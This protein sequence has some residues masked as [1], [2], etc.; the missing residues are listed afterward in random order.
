[1]KRKRYKG[2]ITVFFSLIFTII[3]A[4]ICTV[5]ESARF[6]AA[7]TRAKSLSYMAMESEFAGYGRQ[8]FD[9]YGLLLVYEQ[10]GIEQEIEK[11]VTM[12]C[13]ISQSDFSQSVFDTLNLTL[14]SVETRKVNYV[15]DHGGDEYVKQIL[16]FE[17]YETIGNAAEKLLE[18]LNVYKDGEEEKEQSYNKSVTDNL[19]NLA[20]IDEEEIIH[21][22]AKY[23]KIINE[24]KEKEGIY[25]D[26]ITEIEKIYTKS[27]STSVSFSKV[28]IKKLLKLFNNL[29]KNLKVYE[30][31]VEEEIKISEDYI[32]QK[33]KILKKSESEEIL[34]T[35]DYIEKNVIHLRE[36]DSLMENMRVDYVNAA[37]QELTNSF[38]SEKE[39]IR[40][41]F[42]SGM[43]SLW[44]NIQKS[45]D[46]LEERKVS[47]E[48]KRNLNVFE[49]AKSLIRTGVLELVLTEDMEVSANSI[50]EENL[51]SDKMETGTEKPLNNIVNK[52]LFVHYLNQRFD[53][54]VNGQNQNVF[55]YEIEYILV[56]QK[57]DKEN[58]SEIISKL[59]ASRQV[60]NT[61]S[62]LSDQEKITMCESMA[63]SI[64]T[65]LGLPFMEPV[66]K[67][68]LIEAWAFAESI[69]DV[70]ILLKGGKVPVTKEKDDWKCSLENL[71]DDSGEGKNEKG[72]DYRTYL[73]ILLLL[74]DNKK[75]IY[76]SMD[77]IQMNVCNQYNPSFQ[78]AEGITSA[79]VSV[80]YR[81]R[82]L[83]TD[84]PFVRSILG[85]DSEG[86]E[87]DVKAEY[88]YSAG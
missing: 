46:D 39:A 38:I 13:S 53:D 77:L 83:F 71:T 50:S 30:E 69:S 86:Y 20:D 70:R 29:E 35:K 8:I 9:D 51:P 17:K 58:L 2:S 61:V 65:A 52:A 66:A 41:E 73:N 18:N 36:I 22:A 88:S 55:Q 24:I 14:N 37:I 1:M 23:K 80:R 12:N 74:E 40:K 3:L 11:Y 19:S 31:D 42:I 6:Y 68:V 72:L 15:T 49:A 59:V 79:E 56:G 16:D 5:T 75:I 27:D 33:Q 85:T 45:L 81:V 64:S 76:R 60:F 32:N 62:L 47:K 63:V 26:F 44:G 67:A 7:G 82:R 87:F 34:E 21:L 54:Y 4:F 78:L 10:T 57:S 43:D 84:L 28:E 25:Q 48:D